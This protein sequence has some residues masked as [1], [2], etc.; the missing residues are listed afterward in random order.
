M[1]SVFTQAQAKRFE[2][3]LDAG[4]EVEGVLI[5]VDRKKFS[6]LAL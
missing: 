2:Y 4:V 6:K 1:L 3:V 5:N